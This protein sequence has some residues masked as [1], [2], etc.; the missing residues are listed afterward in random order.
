MLLQNKGKI[1]SYNTLI[2]MLKKI[3]VEIEYSESL[4]KKEKHDLNYAIK[5]VIKYCIRK[6]KNY[7]I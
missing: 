2:T 3:C 5:K 6:R 4:S 7:E 1:E